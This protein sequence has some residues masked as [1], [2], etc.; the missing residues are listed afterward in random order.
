MTGLCGGTSAHGVKHV[1]KPP[2]EDGRNFEKQF[3]TDQEKA[4]VHQAEGARAS[5][6]GAAVHHHRP[7]VG[8]QTARLPNLEQEVEEGGG[9]L[10]D[11]E[12]GP[13]GV[14]EVEHFTGLSGLRGKVKGQK[15]SARTES[16]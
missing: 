10:R 11:P 12:V 5:D 9:R 7:L 13:G 6:A 14:V 15:N 4:G 1:Q 16:G 3:S 8:A 2:N